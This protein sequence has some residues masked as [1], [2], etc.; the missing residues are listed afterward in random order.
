MSACELC[1]RVPTKPTCATCDPLECPLCSPCM[2]LV[3]CGVCGRSIEKN[4]CPCSN[5]QANYIEHPKGR[6][7]EYCFPPFSVPGIGG[8]CCEDTIDS[9]ARELDFC[10]HLL[11]RLRRE[12]NGS[13]SEIRAT[14]T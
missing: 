7:C 5:C 3:K 14:T 1:G 4:I 11:L 2:C 10:Q 6:H 13:S 12:E 9:L 8:T